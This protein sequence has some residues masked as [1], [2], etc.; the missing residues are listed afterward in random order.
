MIRP[1]K[2]HLIPIVQEVD[3][4]GRVV[5]EGPMTVNDQPLRVECFTLEQI[6]AWFE[7]PDWMPKPDEPGE[8]Q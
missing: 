8:P 4:T 3:D 6:A 2:V 7:G 5:A 1:Y